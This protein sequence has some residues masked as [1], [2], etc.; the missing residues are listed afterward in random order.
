MVD[1]LEMVL[2]VCFWIFFSNIA[3]RLLTLFPPKRIIAKRIYQIIPLDFHNIL[4]LIMYIIHYKI[5]FT[6]VTS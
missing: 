6:K 3:F 2:S 4:K 5:I 1:L